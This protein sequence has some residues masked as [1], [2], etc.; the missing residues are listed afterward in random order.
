M[1]DYDSNELDLN[2]PNVFRDLTKPMGALH[3]EEEFRIRYETLAESADLGDPSS[4]KPFHYGTHYSSAGI[5]LHYL[6]R[7]EPFTS[8]FIQLQGGKFDLADRLFS[9]VQGA[10]KSAAGLESAQNGTQDVKELIPEFFYLPEFLE[11]MNQHDFGTDQTGTKVDTVHLPPWAHGSASEFVRI[12]REALESH[13]VSTHLHHWIDLI[14]GYK[15][16]GAAAVDACNVFYY[17]TY[18]GAVDLDS[19]SDLAMKR[20]IVDQIKEFGQTPSQLF[21]SPHPARARSTLPFNNS[22]SL[23]GSSGPWSTH[24]VS[25]GNDAST[26]GNA[27]VAGSSMST[28]VQRGSTSNTSRALLSGSF[29]AMDGGE[30]INRMQTILTNSVLR[31]GLDETTVILENAPMLQQE[32]RREMTT[33]PLLAAYRGL[34]YTSLGVPTTR[35]RQLASGGY[36]AG[37]HQIGLVSGSVGRDERYVAV[38][39]NCLLIPPKNNEY[40][41]W[42]F[43]DRSLKVI[44][45]GTYEGAHGGDSKVIA[46]F[47]LDHDIR[48]AC[49]TSDGRLVVTSGGS[50]PALRVWHYSKKSSGMSS[51]ATRRRAYTV[52]IHSSSTSARSMTLAATLSTP[53][54]SE[55]ITAVEVSRA[56]SVIVSGCAG[57]IAVLWDLNRMRFVRTLPCF[58]KR[59][60]P[61]SSRSET[62]QTHSNGGRI[63]AIAIN[64]VSGDIVI[65]CRSVFGV[66][67][68]NANLLVRL[69]MESMLHDSMGS[70]QT[71]IV[72]IALN[73]SE[74]SAWSKE[75]AVITGHDNGELCLWAYSQSGSEWCIELKGK[76]LASK[77]LATGSNHSSS[78]ALVAPSPSLKPTALSAVY[79]SADERKLYTGNSD[80]LISLWTTTSVVTPP[81]SSS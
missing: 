45:T 51:R 80:G 75:K 11:N 7:I 3:R 63:N 1:S 21:K 66:F 64:E 48:V 2:D 79:L 44:T 72:S 54:H 28:S 35:T 69:E 76:H 10:W 27:I 13:Y 62:M 40:L 70:A 59:S 52:G 15:Q 56:Y 46:S 33:N 73:R 49:I 67:D 25:T 12:N 78:S 37:I 22:G 31:G 18:E 55:S 16:Q 29:I 60:S 38:G 68:I 53:L 36:V 26:D 8:H 5:V 19:V 71:S 14:F 42:A 47:E 9:S 4:T 34:H 43:Q 58:T 74:V 17:L 65:A 20:A 81:T 77:S 23:S 50:S 24:S 39:E 61:L 30:L 57:G 41:A 32:P 6:M